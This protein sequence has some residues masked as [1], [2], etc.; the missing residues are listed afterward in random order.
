MEAL[1][2][3]PKLG[4]R[5]ARCKDTW[6]TWAQTYTNHLESFL[7]LSLSTKKPKNPESDQASQA[8]EE[9]HVQQHHREANG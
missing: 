4:G 6:S 7:A 3:T 9:Y 5:L 1:L 2:V 8:E